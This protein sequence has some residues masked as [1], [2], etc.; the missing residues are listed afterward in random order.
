M[1]WQVGW[2]ALS[3]HSSRQKRMFLFLA[4]EPGVAGGDRVEESSLSQCH[5]L[6]QIVETSKDVRGYPLV[7]N[8]EGGV[9]LKQ[10]LELLGWAGKGTEVGLLKEVWN[11]Y[12]SCYFSVSN[13]S[14]N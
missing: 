6:P 9:E 11:C 5:V 2:L 8:V 13:D 1:Q 4:K 14:H 10:V 12:L 7:R 3:L